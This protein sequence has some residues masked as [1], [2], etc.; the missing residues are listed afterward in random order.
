MNI[1]LLL[2]VLAVLLGLLLTG[3]V[4]PGDR[5]TI[6]DVRS[7]RFLEQPSG[8]FM[9]LIRGSNFKRGVRASVG[10]V[11][12]SRVEWLNSQRLRITVPRASLAPGNYDLTVTNRGGAKTTKR[13]A[14]NIVS[15]ANAPVLIAAGDIAYCGDSNDEATASLVDSMPGTV[16]TLGDNAYDYGTARQFSECYSPSW[17]R[18]RNRTRPVPGNHDYLTAGAAGYFGY[19]EA[20]A[21][22]ADK[23]YYSFNHAGWHIIALNSNCG[24]VGGCGEGSAQLN[25]LKRDLAA[26]A[27]PCTLAY[28]HHPRYNSGSHGNQDFVQPLWETLYDGGADVV[29]AGHDHNYQRFVPLDA[30]GNSSPGGMR[31]FVVGTG[32]RSLYPFSTNPPTVAVRSNSGYG[33][34]KLNLHPD[35]YDWRFIP[36]AAEGFTDAGTGY[37]R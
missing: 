18:F 9:T 7:N 37:C 31:S 8:N 13:R 10:H 28:L 20:R 15:R 26:S 3:A 16:L 35:S 24:D 25:W 19:F 30:D 12:A 33:V 34:L 6:S 29:L 32:G 1:K 4:L 11:S 17:G 21:G 5:P 2:P 36:V 27:A 14:I 23:G 22:D